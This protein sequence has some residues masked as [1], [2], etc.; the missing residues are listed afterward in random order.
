MLEKDSALSKYVKPLLNSPFPPSQLLNPDDFTKY[1]GLRGL[2]LTKENLEFFDMI[3]IL[4][5]IM[6]VI[7]PKLDEGD[8]NGKKHYCRADI[9]TLQYYNSTG[10]IELSRDN[11][12]RPWSEYTQSSNGRCFYYHPYQIMQADQVV[13]AIHWQINA[14]S[15]SN[16]NSDDIR[17]HITSKLEREK[18]SII[19]YWIPWIA[20]L[21]LLDDY[22]GPFIKSIPSNPYDISAR[23]EW[24]KKN[25]EW[26][27]KFSPNRIL[28]L[29]GMKLEDIKKFYES[30][31]FHARNIDPLSKWFILQQLVRVSRMYQLKNNALLAQVM[32]SQAIW[33]IL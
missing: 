12:F 33:R 3:G 2:S 28:L 29:S 25:E 9:F 7:T 20:L 6:R 11:D 23:F 30:L 24:G 10:L 22:Y 16:H 31:S 26:R 19:K 14:W 5:P 17:A 8:S 15:A 18:R 27:K 1:V 4:R 32:E 13:S 21:I